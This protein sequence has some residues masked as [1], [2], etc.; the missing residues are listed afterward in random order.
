M[1]ALAN[2]LPGLQHPLAVRA[3]P[4]C[5]GPGKRR[6]TAADANGSLVDALFWVAISFC[7]FQLRPASAL[8]VVDLAACSLEHRLGRDGSC[9]SSTFHRGR[10]FSLAT[11]SS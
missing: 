4:E 8:A 6:P 7:L 5:R 2:H 3:D 1:A 10:A 11:S 9:G